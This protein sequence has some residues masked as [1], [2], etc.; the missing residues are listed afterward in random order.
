MLGT[1]KWSI[2]ISKSFCVS[3]LGKVEVTSTPEENSFF[4]V[5]AL[6]KL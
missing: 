5:L 6:L 4:K 1:A 2:Y 3:E